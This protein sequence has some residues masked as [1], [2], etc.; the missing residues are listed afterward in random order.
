MC[1][2]LGK[3]NHQHM[4]VSVV[5]GLYVFYIHIGQH[6]TNNTYTGEGAVSERP[7]CISVV[8]PIPSGQLGPNG[9]VHWRKRH[10]LF[11]EAKYI[12]RWDNLTA[13]RAEGGAFP[14]TGPVFVDLLWVTKS[15]AHIP[16]SDNALGRVKAYLDG[17]QD[18]GLYENDRQVSVRSIRR[19]VGTP[20]RVELTFESEGD[21]HEPAV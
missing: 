10:T 5:L 6:M 2:F 4:I 1:L 9:R 20:A 21:A 18:A 16:D 11:Q 7:R 3:Q 17:G 14:W 13:M 12:A 8:L 15:A 19:D